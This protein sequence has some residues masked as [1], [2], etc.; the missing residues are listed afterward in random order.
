METK[1]CPKCK[2]EKSISEFSKDKYQKDG[3][4]SHCRNCR[5][6]DHQEYYGKNKDAIIRRDSIWRK[7]NPDKIRFYHQINRGKYPE[8]QK[9]KYL[10]GRYPERLIIKGECSCDV[11]KKQKHHPDYSKPFEVVMLCSNCHGAQHK[12]FKSLSASAV[13]I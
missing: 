7:A 10:A 2:I 9:A 3:L 4:R 13:A 12:K 6:L 11:K 5:S 1:Y 8:K